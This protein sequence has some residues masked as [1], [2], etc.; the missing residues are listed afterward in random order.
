M[1]VLKYLTRS[2]RV[3]RESFTQCSIDLTPGRYLIAGISF[4][5][6]PPYSTLVIRTIKKSR[7]E[8]LISNERVLFH[9]IM[10]ELAKSAESVFTVNECGGA[11]YQLIDRM[12]GLLVVAINPHSTYSMRV[13]CDCS[14]SENVESVVGKKVTVDKIS[15]RSACVINV[16]T[17]KDTTISYVVSSKIK[18]N[19]IRK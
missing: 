11:I 14:S 2:R 10:I 5:G 9:K 19:V 3:V 12:T 18:A 16:L 1:S 15:P 4:C 13:Y 8:E 6:L 7:I 17:H